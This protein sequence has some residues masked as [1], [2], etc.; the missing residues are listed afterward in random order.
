MMEDKSAKKKFYSLDNAG[1]LYT[2]IASS[3]MTTVYRMTVELSE[4]VEPLTLQKALEQI[5]HRFPYFQV[6]L[7]RGFFWY[8][9]EHTEAIP[10]VEEETYYPCKTMRQRQGKT[11]PFRVLYYKKY[12]HVEFNHSICDGSGGLAFLQTLIIE[13]FKLIYLTHFYFICLVHKYMEI[14][15]HIVAACFFHYC[16]FFFKN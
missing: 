10:R 2:A 12:L 7:K 13:Y 11:F 16:Y 1:V 4:A 9:Y 5:I 15:L 8:Y 14:R 6:T 3:R